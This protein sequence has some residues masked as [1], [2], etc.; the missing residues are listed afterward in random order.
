MD[1]FHRVCDTHAAAAATRRTRRGDQQT[2]G[3]ILG[4]ED[5]ALAMHRV[6][7]QCLRAVRG[8]LAAE[9]M[10]QRIQSVG[11]ELEHVVGQLGDQLITAHHL[12]GLAQ[13]AP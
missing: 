7:R 1:R 5:V 2:G 9:A 4:R 12:A 11:I 6:Q 10:D 8:H 3:R 13:Q